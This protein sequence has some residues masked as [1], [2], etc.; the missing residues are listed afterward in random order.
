VGQLIVLIGTGTSVGKTYV[1][2][3]LL[4]AFALEGHSTVGYKPVE[5]G[6]DE[7]AESDIAKLHGASSFHVKPA[8][9]SLTLKAPVSPHLAARLEKRAIDLDFLRAEVERGRASEADV[10]LVELPGGAF[11][12]LTERALGVDFA[13]MLPDARVLLV[14]PDRL[15]VLHD[16]GAT[17]RACAAAGLP[18]HGLILSAPPTADDSTGRNSMEFPVVTAVPLLAI[19][20]RRAPEAPLESGDPARVLARVLLAA[21]LPGV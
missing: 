19:F 5:S 14:A 7:A 1:A 10:L 3:R 16:V 11:S 18:L 9:T 2:Q 8:L 13:K 21:R 20:P 17:T 6:F 15:G 12:P 4:R